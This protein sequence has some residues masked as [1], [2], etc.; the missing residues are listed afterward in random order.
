MLKVERT[1]TKRRDGAG[2]GGERRRRA[3]LSPPMTPQPRSYR[4]GGVPA[5]AALAELGEDP[6]ET[7]VRTLAIFEGA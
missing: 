7:V 3:R 5:L 6:E 2:R 1:R 4:Y